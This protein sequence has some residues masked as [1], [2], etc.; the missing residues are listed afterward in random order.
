MLLEHLHHLGQIEAGRRLA[1][2]DVEVL[3][4]APERAVERRL[5]LRE[6]HVGLAV[7]PLPVVAHRAL[8]VAD[9]GAVIDEHGRANRVHPGVDEGIDEVPG[10]PRRGLGEVLQPEGVGRHGVK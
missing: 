6:R 5:E 7:A 9:P 4:R 3:D 10:D 2:G 8:G 1:A